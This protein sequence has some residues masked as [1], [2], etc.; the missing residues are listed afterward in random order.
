MIN[1]DI[2]DCAR[3]KVAE[4]TLQKH[5]NMYNELPRRKRTGY[6]SKDSFLSPQAAGNKT[7]RD[8]R[9]NTQIGG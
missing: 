7:P 3:Y 4:A 6:P 9:Q 1:L 2:S 5:E 8:S